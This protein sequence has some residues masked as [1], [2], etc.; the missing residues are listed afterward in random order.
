MVRVA[1]SAKFPSTLLTQA[2]IGLFT[3]DESAII[4]SAITSGA[5][6]VDVDDAS[7]FAANMWLAARGVGGGLEVVKV[8]AVD[9]VLN[10]ITIT[11]A[12][13]GTVGVAH[14]QTGVMKATVPA[15]A[16]NQMR[17]DLIAHA[18]FLTP[19]GGAWTPGSVI[20]IGT[21]GNLEQDNTNLFYDNAANK[22]RMGDDAII[23]FGADSDSTFKYE[24][25]NN[26]LLVDGVQVDVKN[27]GSVLNVKAYGAKGDGVTNDTVPI[28]NAI[29][30]VGA[31]GGGIVF[32]PAGTY[33]VTNLTVSSSFVT[34][35]GVGEK[36]VLHGTAAT[37]NIITVSARNVTVETM[38]LTASATRIAGAGHGI[39]LDNGATATTHSQVRLLFLRI[40]DQPQDGINAIDPE[41]L[42]AE[43]VWVVRA[44]R[45]GIRISNLDLQPWNCSFINCRVD[46]CTDKGVYLTQCHYFTFINLQVLSCGGTEQVN[47]DGGRDNYFL[48]IDVENQED[49]LVVGS[50]NNGM[51][52]SGTH[53]QVVNGHFSS[54]V[55]G[56]LLATANNC[57]IDQPTFTNASANFNMTLAVSVDAASAKNFINVR[58]GYTN[59]TTV[60]SINSASTDNVV[61]NDG[62]MRSGPSVTIGRAD[63]APETPLMV[64]AAA[65]D[66]LRL[67]R[68]GNT[69]GN[70]TKLNLSA[71]DSAGTSQIYSSLYAEIADNTAGSEDGLFGVEVVVAGVQ[72]NAV[73]VAETGLDIQ[74]GGLLIGSVSLFESDRDLAASLIPNADNTLDLGSASRRFNEVFGQEFKVLNAAGD[75][76][77]TAKLSGAILELGVGGATAL[78]WSLART[79]AS[80]A[81]LGIDDKLRFEASA[82]NVLLGTFI[83]ADTV[84]RFAITANGDLQWGSGA[85]A[86]DINLARAAANVIR[87][88]SGDTLRFATDGSTGGAQFGA[89]GDALLYRSAADRLSLGDDDKFRLAHATS[90]PEGLTLAAT[91]AGNDSPRLIFYNEG[92]GGTNGV[93]IRSTSGGILRFSSGANPGAAT[94]TTI[95]DLVAAGKLQLPITG[96]VGGLLIGGDAEW[97]RGAAD[98]MDLASGDSLNIVLGNLQMAGTT[99]FESDRDLAVTLL[100]NADGTLDLGSQARRFNTLFQ[101]G[102][103]VVGVR[104]INTTPTTGTSD[105]YFVTVDS[106]GGA[107]TYNLEAAPN[108]GQTRIVKRNGASNI[109]VDG[110]GKTIDGAATYILTVDDEWVALIYNGT[111]W[112]V[113]G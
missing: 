27:L 45:Y 108:A 51:A 16:L 66:L 94:G 81:T 5:V 101:D 106:S 1:T 111:Q 15:I 73:E 77:P 3:N 26:R 85:A 28:Q 54:L 37:G 64:Y 18:T 32:F 46:D 44:G 31:A 10:R 49:A 36:T 112:E 96:A 97:F 90:V 53:H 70:Q 52:I 79:A 40:D 24:S 89:T 74:L 11:R 71:N 92:T 57:R 19:S 33:A 110:N 2:D 72:T 93:A 55:N 68:N 107:I 99:L 21:T 103:H 48:N 86:A 38:K 34:L 41:L 13:D 17:D 83:T 91:T 12:Q 88:A 14:P 60:L 58:S 87:L 63:V 9:L 62:S 105:D 35:R 56:I 76:N 39:A 100:P 102:G 82:N 6:T 50:N 113:V 43:S 4:A 47:V 75:A 61:H 109:T 95:M 42:Y 23:A 20:F 25:T 30:A 65:A 8:T 69:N 59:V 98:R 22:L 80:V 84:D 67:R 78:D 29:T 104:S 7:A